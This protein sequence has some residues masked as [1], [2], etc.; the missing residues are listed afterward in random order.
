MEP[1]GLR[2]VFKCINIS[3]AAME[4]I[5]FHPKA[6]SDVPVTR[7]TET[8]GLHHIPADRLHITDARRKSDAYKDG[9]SRKRSHSVMK[10]EPQM[11]PQFPLQIVVADTTKKGNTSMD[12]SKARQAKAQYQIF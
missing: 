12:K 1:T 10:A 11:I 9:S 2:D 3:I 6:I 8:F 4:D 7:V 5:G